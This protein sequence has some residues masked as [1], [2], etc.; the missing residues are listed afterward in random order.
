MENLGNRARKGVSLV[1]YTKFITQGIQFI[2]GLILARLLSPTDYGLVG[3]LAIFIALFEML[4]DSGF[5][6]AII[7]K[8]SPDSIDYST[9]FWFNFV[10]SLFL[11]LVLFFSAPAISSFYNNNKLIPILR[12]L[13]IVSVLNAFGSVQGKYLNKN[14]KYESLTKVYMVAFISSS[15]FAVIFAYLGFGVW[16]LVLKSLVLALLLNLGWWLI[17]SWKPQF[18]FSLKSLKQLFGFGSKILGVSIFE[19]L[20]NNLYSLVIGKYFDAQSL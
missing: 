8:K 20:F 12:T 10:F 4:T 19:T 2:F 5:G 11:Y 6:V 18:K 15:A 16:S 13:G 9:V 7:Q 3:M 17:S 1:F 14:L